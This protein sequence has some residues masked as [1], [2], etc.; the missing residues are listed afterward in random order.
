MFDLKALIDKYANKQLDFSELLGEL[1]ATPI[2]SQEDKEALTGQLEEALRSG[3]LSRHEFET[4]QTALEDNTPGDLDAPTVLAA[5]GRTATAEADRTVVRKPATDTMANRPDIRAEGSTDRTRLA[6]REENAHSLDA[7][8]VSPSGAAPTP[9]KEPVPGDL[10]KGRFI[11]EEVLGR[12]GMGVVFKAR[13]LR[14]EEAHDRNPYVAVKVLND[15]FK[16]HPQSLIALQR[17]ARKAQQLAHPNIVTVYDFDRDGDTVYM[18]MEYLEGEPL[19]HI[20]RQHMSNPM[21]QQQAIAIIEGICLGL[22]HA[23]K[24]DTIHSDLKPG[25]VFVTK[26][27]AVK[28]FDFGIAR[29]MKH[30]GTG[31]DQTVFD[32]GELGGLTP[33][34]ASCEMLDGEE[35]DF[36]DDI[37]ALACIAYELLG[38]RHPFNKIPA[39]EARARKLTP[40]PIK[41]LKNRQWKS[42]AKG[43]AF[44]RADRS[45]SVAAFLEPFINTRP[46]RKGYV[47]A[48]VVALIALAGL[49]IA[50]ISQQW[51]EHQTSKIIATLKSGS[52]D[53][54]ST[55]LNKLPT[56]DKTVQDSVL[57]EGK[58]TIIAYFEKRAEAEVDTAHA[59][60]NFSGAEAI[61]DKAMQYYPDSAQ[62]V[63]IITRLNNRKNQLLNE[64]T[65]RFNAQLKQGRL[66]PLP[67]KN[68]VLDSLSQV[69]AIDPQHP[70][71]HDPRLPVA[72]AQ[73]T[74]AAIRA[75]D[76]NKAEKLLAAGLSLSPGETALVNLQDEV[77]TAKLDQA[78]GSGPRGTAGLAVD[79]SLSPSARRDLISRLLKKPFVSRDWSRYVLSN[80]TQLET[81]NPADAA[82]AAGQR[83]TLAKLHLAQAQKMRQ[84]QRYAE[85]RS[86]ANYAKQ[87]NPHLKGVDQE[88]KLIAVEQTRFEQAAAK[89]A[90][91]ASIDGLKQTLLTQAQANDVTKAK[92]SLAQLSKLLPA[93]DPFLAVQGREAIAN[94]YM[95]LSRDLADREQIDQA[96]QLLRAGLEVAPTMTSLQK[97]L[98][99]LTS[100]QSTSAD[101]CKAKFAGY[102]QR[103]RATCA[104][105]LG[106]TDKGPVMVVIPAGGTFSKPFAIGKYEISIADYNIYCRRSKQCTPLSATDTSL[107]LTGISIQQAQH[108]VTWLAQQTGYNYHLP[109]DAEWVYAATAGG[110]ST[111]KDYNCRVVIGDSVVKGNSILSVKSGPSNDWGLTNFVGNAQEWVMKG[112]VSLYARGGSFRDSLSNCDITL[113]RANDGTPNGFTGIRVA[114]DLGRNDMNKVLGSAD[115]K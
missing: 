34:Y 53:K 59:K 1:A 54:I 76:Y 24:H 62:V 33:A 94:A 57:S 113:I 81:G 66:L 3:H 72:Y 2:P 106:G 48:A 60:Y 58:D 69:A 67:N 87:F 96:I 84:V 20:I 110:K 50:P 103:L 109:T 56:L 39:D 101:P 105:T 82:W 115:G 68:D 100:R 18:T 102:G 74:R 104:D 6:A 43:L 70:L 7:T 78:A 49:L 65:T 9:S 21:K 44:S 13:D 23:H 29:A 10:L 91:Q 4:L 19:D 85:A 111:S 93:K 83:M 80:L 89:Q 112:G 14:K 8:I 17:E 47:I 99:D 88:L 92:V 86:L 38:G 31:G 28:V 97:S 107:P 22:E 40:A 16:A 32:A 95:R 35:P 79:T 30:P 51:R 45:P 46:V 52:D 75:G 26:S 42:L 55:T 98:A 114:R 27:G 77:Q 37:Y 63:S 64:Y 25:N 12:G 11:L 73:Q 41:S 90:R 5:T 108:Y 36:R 71:L 61:L 15:S